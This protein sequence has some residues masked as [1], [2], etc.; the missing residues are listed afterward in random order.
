[1]SF[2]VEAQELSCLSHVFYTIKKKFKFKIEKNG[3]LRIAFYQKIA[4]HI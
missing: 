1:M 3:N 4:R 2:R